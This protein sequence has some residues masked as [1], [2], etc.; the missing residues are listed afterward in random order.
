MN[1]KLIPK[2]Y[3]NRRECD[4]FEERAAVMEYDGGL[5]REEAER[6]ARL[7]LNAFRVL[8]AENSRVDS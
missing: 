5:S 2:T 3:S 7:L 6:E 1:G 8:S 4:D